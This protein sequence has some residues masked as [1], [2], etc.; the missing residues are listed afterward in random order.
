MSEPSGR[1]RKSALSEGRIDRTSLTSNVLIG[2]GFGVSGTVAYTDSKNKDPSSFDYGD[3]LPFVPTWSGQIALTWVNE[4]NVKATVAGNYIGTRAGSLTSL[5]G[6]LPVARMDLAAFWTLDASVTWEPLDK[7][8]E[9][10]LAAFNLL[11][12]DFEVATGIP[13]WGRSF[14]GT[15]KVRF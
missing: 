15:L 5:D 1:T 4:A 7:R 13:G 11:D 8:V 6:S 12:E 9:L 3:T 10:S 14:K 2:N